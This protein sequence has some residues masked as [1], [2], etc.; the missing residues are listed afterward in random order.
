[1]AKLMAKNLNLGT[2]EK[3]AEIVAESTAAAISTTQSTQS[4][5][6]KKA[7]ASIRVSLAWVPEPA[8]IPDEESVL[9]LTAP[10]GQYV[11][12]RI[13]LPP[14]DSSTTHSQLSK[15]PINDPAHIPPSSTLSWAFA[16]LATRTED[17]K[18]GRW[19]RLVDNRTTEPEGEV[20]EGQEETLP[21]GDTKETGVMGG[22]EY[23][24]VWRGLDVGSA[25]EVWVSEKKGGDAGMV[26]RVGSWAQGVARDGGKV[27]VFRARLED[28][29]W[30]DV[31]R[32][33]EMSAFPVV[34]GALEGWETVVRK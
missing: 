22:K 9:V 13:K 30:V 15:T 31:Y 6:G 19:S 21:N 4:E 17:G 3:N 28:G 2:A 1:L 16:G 5:S 25:P 8:P 24:E 32:V 33:G 11:D 34:G 23:V 18:G 29:K 7:T 10:T 26:V 12:V 27:N 14:T 20:D